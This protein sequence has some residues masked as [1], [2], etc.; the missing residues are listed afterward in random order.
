MGYR[1]LLAELKRRVRS[2][3]KWL[4]KRRPVLR[5]IEK[6]AGSIIRIGSALKTIYDVGNLPG[7]W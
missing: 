5:R 7:F 2:V 1:K 6:V 4:R 3:R